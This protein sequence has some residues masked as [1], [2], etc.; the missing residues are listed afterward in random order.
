MYSGVEIPIAVRI[1]GIRLGDEI[2]EVVVGDSGV[3][4]RQPGRVLVNSGVHRA[5]GSAVGGRSKNIRSMGDRAA[6]P[7]K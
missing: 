4:R 2:T 1:V 7:R 5:Y 6:F 3:V